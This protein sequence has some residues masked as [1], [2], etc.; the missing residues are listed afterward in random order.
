MQLSKRSHESEDVLCKEE[1][2]SHEA[3]AKII[4]MVEAMSKSISASLDSFEAKMNALVGGKT[5][6]LTKKMEE[7]ELDSR[8]QRQRLLG[9]LGL[10]SEVLWVSEHELTHH[11]AYTNRATFGKPRKDWR[12]RREPAAKD[13]TARIDRTVQTGREV[14]AP[15]SHTDAAC[16]ASFS[17]LVPARGHE[18]DGQ[19]RFDAGPAHRGQ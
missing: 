10:L 3:E 5:E 11:F 9:V 7:M 4:S 6:A 17:T 18:G 14:L 16:T 12:H 1:S 8:Q 13:R 15:F 2:R 19:C